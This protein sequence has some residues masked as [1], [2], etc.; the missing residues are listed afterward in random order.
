MRRTLSITLILV[1]SAPLL[2]SSPTLGQTPV[3][4]L[5]D[6]PQPVSPS[7]L[8]PVTPE[9][10]TLF[11]R[12]SI[13]LV[14]EP[15]YPLN[16]LVPSASRQSGLYARVRDTYKRFLDGP[17]PVPLTPPQKTVLALR[18]LSDPANLAT[19]AGSSAFTVGTNAHTA[20]GPGMTGFGRAVGYSYLQDATGEFFGTILIPWLA[21]QDPRY[22]RMPGATVR[23]RI[24]HAVS[25]V[26]V[27]QSDSG[28]P[29]PNY[30]SLLTNPITAEISNLYVPGI[31]G[32]APSTAS[33]IALGYVTGS[34][35]NLITEFLPDVARHIH[36]RVIFVQRILNQVSNQPNTVQ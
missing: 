24:L 14:P 30:S 4:S 29:M 23:R 32:N 36:I 17:A 18:D 16:S 13:G 9:S 20:Y 2:R 1:L 27:A 26:A 12:F 25:A 34:A 22:H 7:L 21:H 8:T 6:L 31:N 10:A 28:A 19:I 15:P 11:S 35:D 3:P 33:R 5:P